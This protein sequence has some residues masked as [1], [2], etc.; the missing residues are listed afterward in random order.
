VGDLSYSVNVAENY[1]EGNVDAN[2]VYN[3]FQASN[4]AVLYRG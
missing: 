4:A 1:K 3:V 2:N